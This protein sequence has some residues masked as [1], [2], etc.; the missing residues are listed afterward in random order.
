MPFNSCSNH[1]DLHLDSQGNRSR[2]SISIVVTRLLFQNTH[3]DGYAD[4]V[5]EEKSLEERG[6]TDG[7]EKGYV[8]STYA[9]PSVVLRKARVK[10]SSVFTIPQQS[11]VII[12]KQT[13]GIVKCRLPHNMH[14]IKKQYSPWRIGLEGGGGDNDER[15]TTKLR[16]A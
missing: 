8:V 7:E 15:E 9:R 13:F 2:A 16:D 3:Q 5:D 6:L 11:C 12:A 10:T 4:H 1:T 14:Q